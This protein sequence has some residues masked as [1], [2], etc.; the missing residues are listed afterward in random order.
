M[1]LFFSLSQYYQNQLKMTKLINQWQISPKFGRKFKKWS[2][3]LL[4]TYERII[5]SKFQLN[6]TKNLEDQILEIFKNMKFWEKFVYFYISYLYLYTFIYL[7]LDNFGSKPFIIVDIGRKLYVAM[8]SAFLDS[9]GCIC[10]Q[11]QILWR[12]ALTHGG[13]EWIRHSDIC[14]EIRS[15]GWLFFRVFL[16]NFLATSQLI[17]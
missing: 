6:C 17:T 14:E 8:F 2:C 9:F 3:G 16:H 4:R 1:F 13:R 15:W 5:C 10:S 12:N 7:Y 11:R